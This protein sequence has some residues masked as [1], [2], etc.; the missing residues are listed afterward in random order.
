MGRAGRRPAPTGLKQES[1]FNAPE[2]T[3]RVRSFSWVG[4]KLVR[5]GRAGYA[6]QISRPQD[7]YEAVRL[8]L[9]DRDREAVVVLLLDTKHR[10][11][12]AHIVAVGSLNSW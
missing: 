2:A 1:L 4:V 11:N 8:L 6:R 12:A 7:A 9:E 5:E 10:I 3:P